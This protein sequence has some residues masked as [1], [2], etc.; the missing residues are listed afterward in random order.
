MS[1]P[2]DPRYLQ[3]IDYFNRRA[4]FDAHE[5]WEELWTDTQ[6]PARQFYQGLI[7]VAVCLHHFGNGNV[8]GALKLY[9]SSSEYL[10]AYLPR[11]AGLDVEQLLH[12]LDVCCA[13]LLDDSEQ[14]PRATLAPDQVPHIRLC[15]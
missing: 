14:R 2:Y 13:P 8:R 5:V 3:G 6:G 15:L 9:R 7:Q 1:G 11:H 4:F 10:R 12:D